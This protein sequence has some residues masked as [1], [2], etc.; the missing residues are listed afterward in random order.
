MCVSI[1]WMI[2]TLGFSDP[3][4]CS[5]QAFWQSIWNAMDAMLVLL[6]VVTLL[7][8]IFADCSAGERREAMIDTMLLVVR[9]GVQLYRLITVARK[10]VDVFLL[11]N[12]QEDS[13][14]CYRNKR[15]IAVRSSTIDFR[16]VDEEDIDLYKMEE[17]EEQFWHEYGNDHLQ[18]HYTI[19][20]E[21]YPTVNTLV[22]ILIVEKSIQ[23]TY[24]LAYTFGWSIVHLYYLIWN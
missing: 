19:D 20:E 6:C 1:L 8:L 2:G 3:L 23:S 11:K 18:R 15:S 13:Y 17:Q 22:Q 16:Y 14:M 7:I 10:Q 24:K 9:N 12:E 21:I 4:I 5:C